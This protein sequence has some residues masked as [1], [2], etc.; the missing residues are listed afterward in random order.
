MFEL[1]DQMHDLLEKNSPKLTSV[2]SLVITKQKI[3]N[4]ANNNNKKLH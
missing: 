3:E 1:L 4:V 2:E